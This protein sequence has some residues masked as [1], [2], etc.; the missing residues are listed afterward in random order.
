MTL[1]SLETALPHA[2]STKQILLRNETRRVPLTIPDECTLQ[3]ITYMFA[4]SA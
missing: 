4:E 1:Q 2:L 3:Q